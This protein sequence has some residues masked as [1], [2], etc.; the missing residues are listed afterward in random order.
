[1]VAGF[2]FIILICWAININMYHAIEQYIKI[3]LYWDT[4]PAGCNKN[5]GVGNIFLFRENDD[6]KGIIWQPGKNECK[7]NPS[8]GESVHGHLGIIKLSGVL[9]AW[10]SLMPSCLHAQSPVDFCGIC[11]CVIEYV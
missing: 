3:F 1:M 4:S 8:P 2:F 9:H 7:A 11:S 5:K 10:D 6:S